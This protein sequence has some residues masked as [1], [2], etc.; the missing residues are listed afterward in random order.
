[1]YLASS[2][3]MIELSKE[4]QEKC[5]LITSEGLFEPTCMPQG[6]CNASATFQRAMNNIMGY[7]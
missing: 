5:S 6:L 3:W 7:L 2:Y 4:D 1:M